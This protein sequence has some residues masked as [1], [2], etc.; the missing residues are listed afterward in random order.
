MQLHKEAAKCSLELIFSSSV[1]NRYNKL[2]GS[3][4][5]VVSYSFR[6]SQ[7]FSINLNSSSNKI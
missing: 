6:I 4:E 5:A 2:I 3:K 1:V 7:Q